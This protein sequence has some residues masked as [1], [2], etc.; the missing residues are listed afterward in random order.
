MQYRSSKKCAQLYK[1]KTCY[2]HG[3]M[4]ALEIIKFLEYSLHAKLIPIWLF[5]FSF[6]W[7]R[8]CNYSSKWSIKK[9]VTLIDHYLT[10]RS[11]YFLEKTGS[12]WSFIKSSNPQDDW[13][14]QVPTHKSILCGTSF[15][16][17][18]SLSISRKHQ[19][20]H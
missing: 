4:T 6:I 13:D 16:Y 20:R 14:I 1:S 8:Y 7:Q 2:Y 10:V 19:P 3:R 11:L 18:W 5:S 17:Q 15:Q 9:E 12:M